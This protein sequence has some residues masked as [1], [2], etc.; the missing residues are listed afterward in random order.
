M[1][2]T[3]MVYDYRCQNTIDKSGFEIHPMQIVKDAESLVSLSEKLAIDPILYNELM[4]VQQSNVYKILQ[5]KK[6]ALDS[7]KGIIND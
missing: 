5:E 4:S 2:N 7:I 6:N 3:L 1:N